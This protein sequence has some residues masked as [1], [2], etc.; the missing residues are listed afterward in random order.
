MPVSSKMHA[1]EAEEANQP[2]GDQ[3]YGD[4]EVQQSGHDENQDASN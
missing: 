3:V 4:D 1:A 2:D